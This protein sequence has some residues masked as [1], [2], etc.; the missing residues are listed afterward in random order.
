MQVFHR[1]GVLVQIVVAAI[2]LLAAVPAAR[3]EPPR[4]KFDVARVVACRTVFVPEGSEAHPHEKLVRATFD[5][6]VLLA[7]GSEADVEQLFYRIY[8]PEE[9]IRVVDHLPRTEVGSSVAGKIAVE[10]HEEEDARLGA[11]LAGEYAPWVTG[12]LEGSV[13]GK[14]GVTIK[15]ELLPKQ[16]LL[17]ASGTF[18][19][20]SGVFYK[21]KPGPQASLEGARQFVVLFRVPKWWRGETL[22]I[23]CQATGIDR[24]LIGALDSTE[25]CGAAR[26]EIGLHQAGDT[27]AQLAMQQYLAAEDK[28]SAA[29]HRHARAVSEALSHSSVPG[30]AE[31]AAYVTSGSEQDLRREL[32]ARSSSTDK[33]HAELP[34]EVRVAVEGLT[35]ARRQ[36]QALHEW[37]AAPPERMR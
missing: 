35:I 30:Y 13:G 22:V 5:V 2:S 14:T 28:L 7:G 16:E 8:S 10:K 18:N 31:L 12:S 34:R 21:L 4:V 26:F 17:A 1:S 9:S 37:P 20:A 25:S 33:H 32:L 29:L 15:Y 3:A 23:E 27:A 11:N 24:G 19:R 6:S 36:V